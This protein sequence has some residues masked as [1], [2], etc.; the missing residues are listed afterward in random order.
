MQERTEKL[1]KLMEAHGLK[2]KDVAK[3]TSRSIITV[4]Q[5]RIE[6]RVIPPELLR[7]VELECEA[8]A[9]ANFD[10]AHGLS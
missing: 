7:L 8:A 2:C 5:W 3:T 10:A 4:R 6:F 9:V 1:R